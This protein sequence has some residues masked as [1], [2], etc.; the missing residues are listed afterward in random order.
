MLLDQGPSILVVD[1]DKANLELHARYVESLG[2][3]LVLASSG[4]E[5][6][7]KLK[8]E[9]EFVL[10]LMDVRMPGMGGLETAEKIRA[11][12]NTRLACPSPMRA[13]TYG[14]IVAGINPKRVSVRPNFVPCSA[15]TQSQTQHIPMPPPKA[16][17]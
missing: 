1:D 17:P 6:L 10:I 12:I 13:M 14:D 15:I 5:A 2:T 3:E 4:V 7:E 9:R 16:P 11:D 8:E